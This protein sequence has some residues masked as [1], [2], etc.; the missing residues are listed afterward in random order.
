MGSLEIYCPILKANGTL[1]LGERGSRGIIFAYP[2]G[3]S[4]YYELGNLRFI[5]FLGFL[6]V[7]PTFE[8]LVKSRGLSLP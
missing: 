2:P 3:G 1:S 7:Y 5:I 4:K 6:G 8:H